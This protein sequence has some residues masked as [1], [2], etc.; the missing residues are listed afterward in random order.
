MKESGFLT[1]LMSEMNRRMKNAKIWPFEV[2]F[3]NPILAKRG[4][5]LFTLSRTL[6]R[7]NEQ[8]HEKIHIRKYPSWNWLFLNPSS[9]KHL[10]CDNNVQK[11]F[12]VSPSKKKKYETRLTTKWRCVKSRFHFKREKIQVVL[13]LKLYSSVFQRYHFHGFCSSYHWVRGD[14]S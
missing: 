12:N 4:I 2:R 14:W 5:L 11:G 1:S 10:N 8:H 7:K 6:F 9:D 3:Q 13:R